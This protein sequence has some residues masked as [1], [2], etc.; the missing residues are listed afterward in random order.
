MSSTSAVPTDSRRYSGPFGNSSPTDLSGP[1]GPFPSLPSEALRPPRSGSGSVRLSGR[2]QATTATATEPS[3][4]PLGRPAER[5][6]RPDPNPAAFSAP[7][8]ASKEPDRSRV[9]S[10]A[11]TRP[12]P[13]PRA[14]ER[15]LP[16]RE[17]ELRARPE[18][19][20]A[21]PARPQRAA[22]SAPT[23][24]WTPRRRE[25]SGIVLL[26]LAIFLSLSLGSLVVSDGKLMG[27]VGQWV[28]VTLYAALGAGTA[29]LALGLVLLAVRCLRAQSLRIARRTLLGTMGIA[30]S[31]AILLHLGGA[32][33]RL[34]NLPLG[35]ALGEYAAELLVAMVGTAGTILA[36]VM[37]LL[38]SLLASTELSLR[39][40]YLKSGELL[41]RLGA[42]VVATARNAFPQH[43]ETEA[44]EPAKSDAPPAKTGTAILI[45]AAAKPPVRE[46][47]PQPIADYGDDRDRR[48]GPLAL[49]RSAFK[50]KEASKAVATVVDA[51]PSPAKATA[52]AA[53][54][55]VDPSPAAAEPAS[56]GPMP[57]IVQRRAGGKPAA[58]AMLT[59]D[60]A[61]VAPAAAPAPAPAA[62]QRVE[63]TVVAAAATAA[64]V[65]S[66][67]GE[68]PTEADAGELSAPRA[69]V[70][71]VDDVE[72][73]DAVALDSP[74]RI[75]GE[76]D[77][78][79]SQSEDTSPIVLPPPE[80]KTAQELEAAVAAAIAQN[81]E[82]SIKVPKGHYEALSAAYEPPSLSFL[83]YT[84]Q[85]QK[86]LD[87]KAMLDLATRLELTLADYAVKG[88]VAA[89][90]PGPVVTMYEFVPAPGIKL[91]KIT[92]LSNDLAMALEALRVRIVAPI[93]G[94]A[95]VGIEVPNRGRETVFLK[96]ILADE[97]FLHAKTKLTMALGKDISGQPVCVDLAKM[98]HLLVAGTTGS[99]KSVSVNGMVCSLLYNASPDDVKMIMI[100]PK[101]L[102]L[103]IYEGIPH[104]LLPVVTDPKKANLALRWA[105]EE[106]ERRYELISK[107]GVRDLN[108]YNKKIETQLA[109]I[110]AEQL[111]MFGDKDYD[112][113]GRPTK[114]P[115]IVVLIDEF[116][117]L[118]MVAAKE[119]EISVA[120]IAQKARAAGIHL[121]LAT[122]RPS[123]DVITGL[124]K[125]N[126]PSRIA[127]QVASRIDSRTILDAQGAENLLGMGDM[128]FTD[129]GQALRRIHGPL[130]TDVEIHRI[131]EHLKRQGKPIYDMEILKPRVDEDEE[132]QEEDMSDELYDQAV[133]LV[134]D[135]RQA[136]ISMVQRK[137]RI[138]YNR[139]ARMI[140]RMEREGIVSSPDGAK[141]REVLV[142]NH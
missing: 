58:A 3:P 115:Y 27:P 10:A 41:H 106:M 18:R 77:K 131:V 83:D 82:P 67:F 40:V 74:E 126:F 85:G 15:P 97:T 112:L 8:A 34:L 11:A 14:A 75:E 141:G 123:V 17:S 9:A 25:A 114:L 21:V 69:A 118:M 91:S 110:E 39:Q 121:I 99:G 92:A 16:R 53:P 45:D 48:T 13:E 101:M 93:P 98:P 111:E 2:P 87:R 134:V 94:K 37:G 137:L 5:I 109:Q 55:I 57:L 119:V 46:G 108:G 130:I 88:R 120:R 135:S 19:P 127:F 62:A 138:G 36:A 60:V 95:A 100:D 81:D 117:D 31:T 65:R 32:R 6:V 66:P 59:P 63:I 136:S 49:L 76:V 84:E 133:R 33:L 50:K 28:A 142:Q 122:Q 35:G 43:S 78:T 105:V 54:A 22:T 30:L 23:S 20:R 113:S 51:S 56:D 52:A 140:E 89:I 96:E 7:R 86:D 24:T 26:S 4:A 44:A 61:V 79:V 103:S 104:L 72:N 71:L 64:P 12:S 124:I 1:S 42:F 125:A 47:V 70:S 68:A 139:S 90:H 73:T 129:R 132:V 80:S 116:A 38:L 102:E 107:S 128:L 29:A